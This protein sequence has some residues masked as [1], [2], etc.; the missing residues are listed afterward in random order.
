MSNNSSTQL[1]IFSEKILGNV[2]KVLLGKRDVVRS[3]I[4]GLICNGNILLEDVPGVGKT[5]LAKGIAR[6][7]DCQFNRI[8]FTPDLLPSDI[9]GVSIYQPASREFIFKPGPILCQ[10]LLADEINR[11]TPKTQ[12]A[13]LEAMEEHQITIDGLTHQL[14]FPFLVFA[15]QNPIEY[16]GTFPLPEA[17]LDRFM[18][19]ISLGYPAELEEIR[20]LESQQYSHPFKDL[21]SVVDIEELKL[22]QESVKS[23]FVSPKIKRYIVSIIRA[24]RNH[25]DAYLGAS[26]RGSIQ[27]FKA[28]QAIAGMEGRGF[29]IPDDVKLMAE[30]VLS[31]RIITSSSGKSRDISPKRILEDI[32]QSLPI[33]DIDGYDQTR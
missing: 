1:Q 26:P 30:Q 22:V 28:S 3:V 11:A 27:L 33:P 18:M 25:T 17:Q 8:Q 15:T 20:I 23:I 5:M 9:L 13:L 6:S 19:K 12:S 16:E 10:V 14:P 4:V 2:E 7:I 21:K 29:V 24:T 32:F 31:H